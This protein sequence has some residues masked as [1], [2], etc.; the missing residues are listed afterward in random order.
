MNSF[1]TK[2]FPTLYLNISERNILLLISTESM[3][4]DARKDITQIIEQESSQKIIKEKDLFKQV[5]PLPKI[6]VTGFR[7]FLLIF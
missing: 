2:Q 5:V 7:D 3:D 4:D 6:V 1:N